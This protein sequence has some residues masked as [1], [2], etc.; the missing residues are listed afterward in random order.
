MEIEPL[1]PSVTA[2]GL[3]RIKEQLMGVVYTTS[4]VE[5]TDPQYPPNSFI[6]PGARR[7][8]LESG[9]KPE[10]GKKDRF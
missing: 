8:D 6:N 4:L 7:R 1:V 5:N 2:E 3:K 10:A 9:T